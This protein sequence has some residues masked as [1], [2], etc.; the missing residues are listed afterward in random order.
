MNL[1]SRLTTTFQTRGWAILQHS[2]RVSQAED[3]RGPAASD[4]QHLIMQSARKYTYRNKTF[5]HQT[6]ASM[7]SVTRAGV[8][9]S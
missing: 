1:R 2:L 4:D 7:V 8:M 6:E 3:L 5:R 9:S